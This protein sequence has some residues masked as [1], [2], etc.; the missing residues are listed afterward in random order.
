M[1]RR[2]KKSYFFLITI[3]LVLIASRF[4]LHAQLAVSSSMTP[5]QLVQNVLLGSGVTATNITYNGAAVAIGSFNG[6]ASNIGLPS[7]VIL[8]TG[9]IT[10]AIG[11]NNQSGASLSNGRAGDSD[12]DQIMSP[13]YSYDVAILEFDF[14]PVKDT[15]KFRYVFGSEEYMEYV[16]TYPGG[17]NDGFGFFISGPGISGTF[18][19]GAKNIALIPGTALPV[20]MFNLNKNNNGA[21]YF[22]NGNGQSSGGTAPNGQTVQYDGFTVPL[23][24]ITH[25]QCGQTYHIKLAIADGGDHILDSG[26]FLEAGSFSS[27]GSPTAGPDIVVDKGCVKQ[28]I[29][30]NVNPTTLTWTS[31]SPGATGAYNSYL[32]C[33]SGCANP[34]LNIPA[35]ATPASIKYKVCGSSSGCNPVTFCDTVVITIN[36]PLTLSVSPL[37]PVLCFGQNSATLTA[38]A[39][40]GSQPY[41][42]L[43]NNI[44]PSASIVAGNGTYTVK[45]TD[46]SGCP[47]LYATTTVT[48]FGVAASANAG[49]DIN[50]CKQNPT[51]ALNGSVAGAST[52][53]WTGGSGTFNPNNTVLTGVT[54]TPTNLELF[55][56]FVNLTLTTTGIGTCA[57]ASDIVR[58]NYV[59]FS[60]AP[61]ISSTATSCYNGANGSATINM[62]GGN[63]PY[64]Y[65]WN[66][67]P[68]QTGSTAN[69]LTAG[70]YTVTAKDG[71][72]C[73]STN[74]VTVTQPTG[75][76]L[77][78][79]ITNV[80]CFGGNNG[81][82][83][84]TPSGGTPP[85]TYLWQPGNLTTATISNLVAGAYTVTVTDSK[86]CA[87]TVI[88]TVT[89]PNAF[90]ASLTSTNVSCSGGTNGT[91]N[92]SVVGG[93][94]PF[95]YNW[96]TGATSP[97]LT[98]LTAGL[99]TLIVKD[100]KG[101]TATSSITITQPNAV[102]TNIT[103]TKETCSYLN[104]GTA[105]SAPTGGTPG[106]TYLWKPSFQT[107]ATATNL[108]A[109]TYT[110]TVADASNCTSTSTVLIKEPPILTADFSS[111]KNVSCSGGNDGSLTANPLGGTPG[112]TY[113]WAPGGATTSIAA[114][115][116]AGTYSL[117][118]KDANNCSATSSIAIAQPNVLS[119]TVTPINETC[120]YLNNGKA[121][122][123][124]TGGTAGY[125]YV[126]TPSGQ[127]TVTATNLSAG[128]YTVLVKDVKGCSATSQTII[129]EPVTISS[130]FSGVKNVSCSNVSDGGA[131]VNA[132]GG[133]PGYTY[134]W[135][136]GGITSATNNSMGIGNYTVSITD[137]KG[138]VSQNFITISQVNPVFSTIVK[139]DET[140]SY[141]NNG[142]A[143]ATSSGG[144]P[145]HTGSGYT[146]LWLPGGATSS[147]V[148]GLSA[149][150]YTLTVTDSLGCSALNTI[151]I[152]EPSVLTAGFSS[153]KN[154]SCFGGNDAAINAN[155]S[156]GTPNYSYVWMP[157][158][159][160]TSSI[161]N[162][163]AGT[164]TL[165][166]TDIKG[167]IASNT[168]AITQPT[169]I[170]ITIN[171]TSET[172][173][174]N[175]NGIAAANVN[176][177]TSGYTYFWIPSAQNTISAS[178]LN[179]G[180]YTLTV[181]DLNG[182]NA[183][184]MATIVEPP[185]VSVSFTAIKSVSCSGG[186]DGA[187]TATPSGGNGGPYSYTWLPNGAI[188]QTNSN[189]AAGTYTVTVTDNQGCSAT[190]F[191]T[192]SE[193]NPIFSNITQTDET[194]SYLNNGTASV[195]VF[196]GT[197][198]TLGYTYLWQPGNYTAASLTNLAANTYT[199]TIIDSLGCSSTN[200]VVVDE[201]TILTAGFSSQHNVSC[202][203]LNDGIISANTS[204]G[205]PNYTYLWAP[206]GA[207]TNTISNLAAGTY[208]L[209]VTDMNSCVATN[210]VTISQPA[211]LAINISTTNETCDYLNN[212][213]ANANVTGGIVPYTYFWLP[214]AQ[215]TALA[216]NLSAGNY[217]LTVSDSNGC[218]SAATSTILQPAPLTVN[219]SSIKDVS[220]FKG[221]N[222]SAMA[223][224]GGGGGS[225]TYLW[226]PSG[227]TT[228]VD[229]TLSV[230]T[231]TLTVTDVNNCSASN[232]ISINQ[233]NAMF[234][235][236]TKT[237]KTC[238]Y[239]NNGSV[240][241]LANGGT[242][243]VSGYSYLW[244]PGAVT[245]SSVLNLGTGTY[246]LTVN[247]SLGCIDTISVIINEPNALSAGISKMNVN[248][249]GG[250]DAS[251]NVVPTGGTP[252]YNYVWTP[253]GATTN[254]ISNLGIG[255]Y[256]I[257]ITDANGC[258]TSDS[259]VI[260]QPTAAL[261]VLASATAATCYNGINGAVN[262]IPAGGTAPY[263]YL[264]LPN[265]ATT[266]LN[267]NLPV[268][269]YS[270]TV[271]DSAGCTSSAS[272]TV[273]QPA[274]M[275]LTTN[276]IN[277]NCGQANGKAWV[278]VAGA[279]LP[280]TYS[281]SPSGGVSDTAKNVLAGSYT[282]T[283][284]DALG[285][286][287]TKSVNV[288]ENSAPVASI[289][290]FTNV[291]CSG[292][293]NGTATV[294]A[295]GG[296]APYTYLWSTGA[297]TTTISSLVSG[298]YN[299]TV[300]GT[301][302]CQTHAIATITEPSALVVSIAD[303]LVS[304]HSG[305]DGKAGATVSGGTPVYTYL[306]SP[307]GATTVNASNLSANTY[308]LQ[309]K[310]ANLCVQTQ[311]VVINEPAALSV[312]K[313]SSQVS[314][315]GGMDGTA[316]VI[317]AGG[318]VPY[319]FNWMPGNVS[320]PNVSQLSV[321]TYTLTLTDNNGCSLIDSVSITQPTK[322]T[323]TGSSIKSK[324]SLA[325]GQASVIAVGGT[326]V[327]SY[328]W[329]PFGGSAS[330]ATSLL[331]GSYTVSVTDSLSCL[332]MDT[333]LVA[334]DS[335]PV[336][337]VSS[338][339][340]IS[341]NGLTNG[342]ATATISGGVG[343]YSY[344]WSPSGAT[345]AI[346][347]GLSAGTH[348]VTVT[349]NNGCQSTPAISAA[350]LE[351][352][353][354][355]IVLTDT[356][357]TC[358]GNGSGSIGSSVSGGTSGY[359]YL[360]SPGGNTNPH[361]SGLSATTYTLQVT[362]ANT[363]SQS[364][365]VT[366]TEPLVLSLSLTSTQVSCYGGFD[367]TANALA[368][369]GTSPY[370]YVW[371]PG[372]FTSPNVG[373]LSKGTYTLTLTDANACSLVDSVIISQPTA[374]ALTPS[375]TK[376]KCS[377]ANGQASIVAAGGT[378][379]YTYQWV[380]TG[381]TTSIAS[382]LLADSYTVSV[383][384]SLGCLA[385]D[386][387]LVADDA[388]PIVTV[389]SI[390][391]I[392]CSGLTDGTAT[393]AVSG[394]VG[395]YTYV[396]SPSGANTPLATG[397]SAGTHTIVVTDNNGCQAIPVVSAAIIEPLPIAIVLSD[398]SVSCFGG[399]TGSIGS[400]VSGGTLGYTYLWSPGGNTTAY[401]SALNVNTY[402]LLVTDANTCSQSKSVIITQ[403][404]ALSVS[405]AS[406]Q[407]SCFGGVDGTAG[408]LAAGGTSPYSY[409]WM[410]GNVTGPSIGQLSAGTYTL[411]LTDANGCSLIDS[412]TISEP[413]AIALTSSST[414]STCS[415]A[416]GIATVN[417]AG[418]TPAY[419]YHWLPAGGVASTASNLLADSYTVSVID[420][421][422]CLA[423]DTILVA[424]D[425]SP[426]VSVSAVTNITCN[427]LTNGTATATISGGVGPYN[428]SWSPSGVTTAVATGLAKGTHTVSVTDGNGCQSIPAI[429]AA[430]TEPISIDIVFDDTAVSCNGGNNGSVSASVSGGTA[431]YTYLWSPGGSTNMYINGLTAG[432]Y[433]LQVTDANI[434][435]EI[436][437]VVIS[438]PL[439]L[440]AVVSSN[441]PVKC[442]GDSTGSANVS[443][444]GGTPVYYFAWSPSGG[445]DST[446]SGFLA[447]TYT[448][449][450]TDDNGCNAS[451]T[452]TINQ[453][454]QALSATASPTAISCNGAADGIIVVASS[455]G[456]LGYSYTWN[457]PVSTTDTALNLI[458]GTY[459]ITVSDAN[460]CQTSA[461][462]DIIEPPVLSG[463]L[464]SVF[465]SCNL[466][467]GSIEAQI[468]GGVGPYTYF[469]TQ[470]SDT[471]NKIT[472]L[473]AGLYNL[474]VTDSSNCTLALSTTLGITPSPVVTIAAH[475][476][477]SCKNGNDGTATASISLGTSPYI[478]NWTP[479]GGDSTFASA[480]DTGMY[481]ITVTD[482]IG[483][484][485]ADSVVIS[486]P[487]AISI[488]IDTVIDAL[489]N[490]GATGSIAVSVTG[491]T[492]SNYTYDWQPIGQTNS[493][494]INL[495]TGTYTINVTDQNGCT[496]SS[497]A[498]VCEP[499]PQVITVDTVIP[500]YCFG[501]YGSATV[502]TS[503]GTAPYY[504]TWSS[505]NDTLSTA[506]MLL[507]GPITVIA[508][509]ANG[510]TAS[511]LFTLTEPAQV[512]T[513]SGGNDTLCLGQSAVLTATAIGGAG[514][515]SYAWQPSAAINSGSLSVTPLVT[516]TYTVVAFDQSGCQGT[517]ALIDAVVLTLDSSNI[518]AYATT[519][520]C[521]GQTASVYVE[522]YGSTTGTLTYQWTQNLGT[523]AGLYSVSPPQTT[524]YLVTVSNSCG[525][526]VSDSVTV[527]IIPPP[528]VTISIDTNI[529]CAPGP[530]LF[531]DSSLIND[532]ND[533]IIQWTW[534]FGDGT[535]SS[536]QN[537]T[538]IY[539]L[540][541]NYPVTLSVTTANGCVNNNTASPFSITG[542]SAPTAA[543]SVNATQLQLPNDA[544][545]INNQSLGANAYNWSFGDGNTSTQVN[546]QYYYTSIGVFQVQLIAMA[547]N[548]CMDTAY[549]EITTDA[550]V[551]FPNAFTPSP[552]GPNGGG[553]S[554][555]NYDND[556]FFPYT[557]GVVEY[558]LEIFNRWGELIFRTVDINIGWDGYYRGVICQ[559]D[560]YVW[561]AY[562][563]LNNGKEVNQTGNVTLLR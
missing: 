37:N 392:S 427:G 65:T 337:T 247:D 207:V 477:V 431:G 402:T 57:P 192:I 206:S 189:L 443:V 77:T 347:T 524:P 531:T 512:I 516:T 180:T 547:Q 125:T 328:Q 172:C 532:P 424:D 406:S 474:Q 76:G 94:S 383:R 135:T 208:T 472:G 384:D 319:A 159:A 241:A 80:S 546:P 176:G 380:P 515:Y 318:T 276:S 56:G 98:G 316:G 99:Y 251:V 85:Y 469:W 39:G 284:T 422:G 109:G 513:V 26:V 408:A 72:G 400:S 309:V 388:S 342:T 55:T 138:C 16:S 470:T 73:V 161:S 369:G 222:G 269:V 14:V 273:T 366:I 370:N 256:S 349:D 6:S 313:T 182:C 38:T 24:A 442:F 391:N 353:Q 280:V 529:F 404:L 330:I 272:G 75:I 417:A 357:L 278:S 118:V 277:S 438:E 381:G 147:S 481:K 296:S 488:A 223:L 335:S 468:A 150:T 160:V 149:A 407:V 103:S 198:G 258:T 340:N 534:D 213:S 281:W 171:T 108:S 561:K 492:G 432:T 58:I 413:S 537:P 446:G 320:G 420:S 218:T 501:G 41:S 239:L 25:V 35:G 434:C 133:T 418:G 260:T 221:N 509:D 82:I 385:M 535:T 298:S 510:C 558:K 97:N 518:K 302:S 303:T 262:A 471:I 177:G 405:L 169:A 74:T 393:A 126:W 449:N 354:I 268:G 81:A 1:L 79:T 482:N 101:C 174:Y 511:N 395:P 210:T 47:A 102:Q 411:T 389:S 479:L 107:T 553:Y 382:N 285:C 162:L 326:P 48:A 261:S 266:V 116:I 90:V 444:S 365:S 483:C 69:N 486:E 556:V 525:L 368:T 31:I 374:I 286:V 331:V 144:T 168:L 271:T 122:A 530:V 224:A 188:S 450:V 356:S 195:T 67:A 498:F 179:A 46:A 292:G 371:M 200:K 421:S 463:T 317:G 452:V 295:V 528:V 351:P 333:I 100:V 399:S 527:Y 93:S 459:N 141:L 394:G 519:P 437:S 45:L 359:S 416:N 270:V 243:A 523:N 51:A 397:L 104:N 59:N 538:H 294:N 350:I 86:Q 228:A 211:V 202:F 283:V 53:V 494:A 363:C 453:P 396:W 225:Y 554:V 458:S 373:Q 504:Y 219:F 136:P 264:W 203:G 83:T 114:G 364:K 111:Q 430:I 115:L 514:N 487:L 462:A 4:S 167:C 197:P 541:G 184:A 361:I 386:T 165:N 376:S 117:T 257:T 307:G 64:V 439:A 181:T 60:G 10:K 40:G 183:T 493:T 129:N 274:S 27:T 28:I 234:T 88:Y 185:S 433:T 193:L 196:G 440:Q 70:T 310:D 435:T 489:C 473:N 390:T 13:T 15:L 244:Q 425:T 201:P 215:T 9:N 282:V 412:I 304:C 455:G 377:L 43:W 44:N 508:R 89:Q 323:L 352:L 478:V 105:T 134:L 279:N 11:P 552:D 507:A 301:N 191:V 267:N 517:P 560:V 66:T 336:A 32:S 240:S 92:S 549:A 194:C 253:G 249:F 252:N 332:V 550:Q 551:N 466:A 506:L 21:Y 50:I 128:V 290:A 436:K 112:Y 275:V 300:T 503:G 84:V 355:A 96:S 187:A 545:I 42:Y 464:L 557:S 186:N 209:T 22:D 230:G 119:T 36:P 526:S 358:N 542:V 18:S 346:A 485:V 154:V 379:N 398:T 562:V 544:L 199:L 321:G 414:N 457:P 54:Y 306:W 314:C 155:P 145:R 157:G 236:I 345:T 216:T 334:D 110:L 491:G 555:T 61:N 559:E 341:C 308:T 20:T 423:M 12:M 156:G 311:T 175:N 543:F 325:N 127:T 315:F 505:S 429:S 475:T 499:L 410:P 415:L 496:Q 63:T 19:N 151:V 178:N 7:G 139:T 288:N 454:L 467:N 8:S 490:G 259:V 497:S 137:N 148:T 237:D 49:A 29:A 484:V 520:I 121:T 233:P 17:I 62:A 164:Y 456:T 403:P 130:T 190:N 231:Y 248:C 250:N 378:P 521:F 131:I 245:T 387:I 451:T 265:G 123:N 3:L 372:N 142:T 158:G 329:L 448:I 255:S 419:T 68:A 232:F 226:T 5:A 548:G 502:S 327:Y 522:T 339:T 214:G 2:K 173:N 428:Y 287:T 30:S 291:S 166:V 297:T 238:N 246:T 220:C 71:A 480:L 52:G 34:T 229:S 132:A 362:D 426:V 540:S 153:Q 227:V 348:T 441:T 254:L 563:K 124:V 367:G 205:I 533:P 293:A 113:L 289:S 170:S 235:T 465:P 217:T 445:I 305:S 344:A 140:C 500:P 495:A 401:V 23:I 539:N 447:G 263:S 33:T 163:T 322:I 338:V 360:W 299:V 409:V 143:T 204:G 95:S 146:Y 91:I 87:N 343:P 106:Y 312:T 476:D 242:P 324:C 212:G 536:L 78:K 461:Q 152:N 375:S 460:N 120:D